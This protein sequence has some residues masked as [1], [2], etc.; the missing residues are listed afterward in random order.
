[1]VGLWLGFGWAWPAIR[2]AY[3]TLAYNTL[4]YDTLSLQC[5]IDKVLKRLKQRKQT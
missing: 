5:T 2:L 3:N 1:L 4:A